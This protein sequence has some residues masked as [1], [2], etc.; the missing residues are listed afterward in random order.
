MV[1]AGNTDNLERLVHEQKEKDAGYK[2][3][4][5]LN[6]PHSEYLSM[7]RDGTLERHLDER[8]LKL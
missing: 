7:Y 1:Q 5:I 4:G 2:D 3:G 6:L 8:C